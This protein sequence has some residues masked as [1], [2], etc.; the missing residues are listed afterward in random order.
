MAQTTTP[1]SASSDYKDLSDQVSTLKQDLASISELLTE[2]GVRRK[3][4]TVAAAKERAAYLRE[5]GSDTLTEA[6]LRAEDMQQQ[7]L[8][9]IRNQPGTAIGIAVGIGFLAG[10]LTSRK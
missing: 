10:L 1:N 6:Q 7:A 8:A 9:A 4:E 5:R 2:I 3:D